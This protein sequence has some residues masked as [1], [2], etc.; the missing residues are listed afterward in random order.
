MPV[1]P[2]PVF[3]S[4][5]GLVSVTT[6]PSS[7]RVREAALTRAW[8]GQRHRWNGWNGRP[9][10]RSARDRGRAGQGER[11]RMALLEHASDHD[12]CPTV[13]SHRSNHGTE[14][15]LTCSPARSACGARAGELVGE[16]GAREGQ[17]GIGR[18]QCDLPTR[19]ARHEEDRE[20]RGHEHAY[21]GAEHRPAVPTHAVEGRARG[22]HSERHAE[23]RAQSHRAVE[24]EREARRVATDEREREHG[25]HA[26]RDRERVAEQAPEQNAAR[27]VAAVTS[28]A[29]APKRLW[30]GWW[31]RRDDDR[32]VAH[33][34]RRSDARCGHGGD[35]RRRRRWYGDD[36]LWPGHASIALAHEALRATWW[37]ST[38]PNPPSPR[39]AR[40]A[41]PPSGAGRTHAAS[42]ALH[43]LGRRESREKQH[44]QRCES[45]PYGTHKHCPLRRP[46]N[47]FPAHVST[48]PVA[49][50]PGRAHTPVTVVEPLTIRLRHTV[51]AGQPAFV[52]VA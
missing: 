30:R 7:V 13:E 42:R 8:K 34:G 23:Q 14:R 19:V 1:A 49:H 39:L 45:P 28:H 10:R 40:P 11:A 41:A 5:F 35:L 47:S 20:R 4:P 52:I 32:H 36:A 29:C 6:I 33:I 43:R 17:Q 2:G 27:N 18:A 3:D 22:E 9:R 37:P 24:P 25:D 44:D 21:E 16:R 15:S 31:L 46:M 38:A 51:A 26:E 50:V 48:F 12:P